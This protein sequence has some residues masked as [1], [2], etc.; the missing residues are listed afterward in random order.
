[1]FCSKSSKFFPKKIS[2]IFFLNK[3]DLNKFLIFSRNE[4][5]LYFGKGIFRTLAYLDLETYSEPW[6]I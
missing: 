1:M 3:P 4:T 5:F 6:H 2:Y